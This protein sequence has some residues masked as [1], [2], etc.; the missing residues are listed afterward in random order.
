M[1]P[2]NTTRSLFVGIA[3]AAEAKSIMEDPGTSNCIGGGTT[4][5]KKRVSVIKNYF[6]STLQI[7]LSLA[8]VLLWQFIRR[9]KS[10]FLLLHLRVPHHCHV[11]FGFFLIKTF[12]SLIFKFIAGFLDETYTLFDQMREKEKVGERLCGSPTLDNLDVDDLDEDEENM[13][14]KANQAGT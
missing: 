6:S 2:P 13:F 8:S 12:A 9:L 14:G 4:R 11:W 1:D 7:S 3:H 5:F 10:M